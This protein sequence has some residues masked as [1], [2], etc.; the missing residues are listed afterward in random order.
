MTLRWLTSR[1]FR[2]TWDALRR[3]E[4]DTHSESDQLKPAALEALQ[5][6]AKE[7]RLK[8]AGPLDK[9][10]MA[11]VFGEIDKVYQ[12]WMPPFLAP[13]IRENV[14]V[15]LVAMVIA[16]AVRTFFLQ[17]MAIPT[18][19]MQPTLYGITHQDLRA[20]PDQ[21]I[22]GFFTRVI[23]RF[24]LGIRYY[25]VIA[26][27]DGTFQGAEAPTTFALFFSKQRFKV[28]GEVYSISGPPDELF[29]GLNRSGLQVG[30]AF[31]KGEPIIR[32]KITA[33]D[34]LFV[35]C[36]SYNFRRP[37]VGE[38][39]IFESTG[40]PQLIQDTHYIKRLT[41][42]GGDTLSIGDDRH[43]VRNGKRLDASTPHFEN[44]Y[45]FEGPP[46]D[47]VFS[48]HVNDKTG[49]A[50]GDPRVPSYG[51]VFPDGNATHK[52]QPGHLFVMGDN[53]M[54]SFDSRYW[55]DFPQE[56]LVGSVSFV[57][58]PFTER[59]GWSVR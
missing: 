49:R 3:L 47:S 21:A 46:R 6:G 41:G 36:F 14:D 4:K 11:A 42:L 16:L 28:G 55:G 7:A 59:F 20:K 44:I 2:R 22:P 15:A 13:G 17:P 12:K 9:A 34:R 54:N 37:R 57:F 39:V 53:T 18:G 45:A 58:W 24:G 26:T 19:S 48:G 43:L 40:I 56:K 32:L 1:N 51:Q 23:E 33:G 35:N 52:V 27:A 31:R 8:L 10:G 25:E 29:S 30:Q 50:H 38:I 5:T